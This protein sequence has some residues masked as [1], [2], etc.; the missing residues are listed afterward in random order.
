MYFLN[1]IITSAPYFLDTGSRDLSMAC[2]GHAHDLVLCCLG[3][4]YAKR[5]TSSRIV[6][7][8]LIVIF[9]NFATLRSLAFCTVLPPTTTT[10]Y[11]LSLTPFLRYPFHVMCVLWVYVVYVF[12][13]CHFFTTV[14]R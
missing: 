11:S 8:A 6:K 5:R 1:K 7:A 10:S 3:V 12:T 9:L 2:G 4:T 14:P 13:F